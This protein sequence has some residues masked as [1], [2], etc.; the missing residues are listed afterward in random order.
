MY[1]YKENALVKRKTHKQKHNDKIKLNFYGLLKK[2]QIIEIY[3]ITN[4]K[5]FRFLQTNVQIL[6]INKHRKTL[7]KSGKSGLC[8]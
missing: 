4:K 7:L 6:K 5:L 3:K 1:I 2:T 8:D